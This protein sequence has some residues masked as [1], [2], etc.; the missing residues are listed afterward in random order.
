MLI[1]K[2]DKTHMEVKMYGSIGGWFVDGVNFTSI[3]D[4][5]EAQG[6][7]EATFRM[8]CYGGSVFEGSVIGN[9]FSRSKMKINIIIDG[10]AASMACMVLPYVPAENIQIAEN[11][12][13]MLHRPSSSGGGDADVHLAAAKLLRDMEGN[14]IKTLSQRTGL[15]AEEIKTKW[16]DSNDHWLNA[17]EMVQYHLAGSK[18]K[19]TASIATLDKQRIENMTEEGVYGHFAASLG[20]G[21]GFPN[22]NKSTLKMKEQLIAAFLLIGLTA[23]SSDTVV[24][25][26][27]QAK[28]KT[29]EDRLVALEAEAQTKK[30][31][32]IKAMLDG[33][34]KDGKITAEARPTFEAIGQTSG[35]EALTTVLSGMGA[36]SPIVNRL[37]PEGKGGAIG[38]GA[39]TFAWYQEHDAKALEAMPLNDPDT[40]KELYKAEYGCYPV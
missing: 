30:D 1:K 19:S 37:T 22:N 13:G 40:F 32:A 8:H 29:N 31:A 26:A 24:L 34:A 33:A 6:I 20:E 38:G 27:L 9:A 16:F 3:L 14:F 18:I 15:T 12:F 36:K 23:E 2:I 10:V 11:A 17:D 21:Q 35:I 4:E 28:F 39:K 5:F 25:A 7:T